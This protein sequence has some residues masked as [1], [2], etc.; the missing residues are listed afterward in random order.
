M[1]TIRVK[2]ARAGMG[3]VHPVGGPLPDKGGLWPNDQFTARRLRDKDIEEPKDETASP[4]A[5]TTAE[6][7][8]ASRKGKEA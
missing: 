1:E 8:P 6:T 2:P 4:N 5:E 7:A 3:L